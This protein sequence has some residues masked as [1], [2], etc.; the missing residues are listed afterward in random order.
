[1]PPEYQLEIKIKQIIDELQ[2]I[3]GSNGLSNTASEEQVVTTVF[4]YKFL[5][6]RFM[7]NLRKFANEVGESV[8]KVLGNRNDELD[9]FY[10]E[11]E[12]DV[13]FHYEDTIESLIRDISKQDF[14]KEFDAALTRISDDLRN[15]KFGIEETDGTRRPLFEPLTGFVQAQSRNNFAKSIFA[16]IGQDK[17][18]FGGAFAESFDFYSSIFEHLIK[19]Y[20]VASGRYAEYFTP[21]SVSQIMARILVGMSGK[22]KASEIY[23]PGA[24]S[25]SLILHLAH[26]LGDVDGINRAIVY[27]QDISSKST[28][29][30]RLNLMLNGMTESLNH[31][32][33]GDTLLHPAHYTKEHDPSSGLKKF[34]Y[35]TCNPPF[36]MDFSSTRDEIEHHWENTDRFLCGVPKIPNKKKDGMEVYVLFIQHILYSMKDTGKA[37]I[38]VPTGFLTA[39]SGIAKKVRRKMIDERILK[40]AISMPSNIFANTGTNVSVLFL[41]RSNAQGQVM[42]IDA[43]KLGT[44][45]KEGRNQRTILSHE[46]DD[47]IVDAFTNQKTVDDFSVKVTYAGIVEKNY[48][49]SAGRYFKIRNAH[50]DVSQSEFDDTVRSYRSSLSRLF[51]KG[52]ESEEKILHTLESMRY[53]K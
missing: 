8:N 47:Q 11:H 22:K 46:E 14:Y 24:G 48:S 29:F 44:K 17:F 51:K 20:N 9:A 35:I 15:L 37:A 16:T 50:V 1:M 43:S 7:Y 38:V 33:E 45:V 36:K 28:R 13:A 21:Q 12:G 10:D 5:N 42:L 6:D 41:D 49:L 18:D 52:Q 31:V 23:D 27:A 3:C 25:G 19:N 4:L 40:G 39:D 34:D 26:E 2:G 32:V 53:E 30:L